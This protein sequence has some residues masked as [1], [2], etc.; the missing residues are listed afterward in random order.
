MAGKLVVEM[1]T[2][3]GGWSLPRS[4]SVKTLIDLIFH[5]LRYVLNVIHH[6]THDNLCITP[7]PVVHGGGSR[8][9][10]ASSAALP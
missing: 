10:V 8:Q 2:P 1:G 3:L 7:S 5:Y 4:I 6:S 9:V